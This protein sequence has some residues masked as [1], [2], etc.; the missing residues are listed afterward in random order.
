MVTLNPNIK[1][2]LGQTPFYYAAGIG[3][4][5]FVKKLLD[6]ADPN[7]QDNDGRTPLHLMALVEKPR[8]MQRITMLMNLLLTHPKININIQDR[9]LKTPA[10]IAALLHNATTLT[11]LKEHGA[12]FF[13]L[14]DCCDQSAI[15]YVAVDQR[16]I[17]F[18]DDYV[19][20]SEE[21]DT[22]LNRLKNL[23]RKNN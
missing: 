4:E 12:D 7:C 20:L 10:H 23:K 14:Q 13:T 9:W 19:Q 3:N 21:N 8:H 22:Q 15:Q 6:I 5:P 18:G 2:I 17:I 16:N 11:I 1:N